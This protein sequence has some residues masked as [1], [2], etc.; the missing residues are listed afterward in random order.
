MGLLE[1]AK[2]IYLTFA[3]QGSTPATPDA[4]H[5]RLFFDDSGQPVVLDDAG[6]TTTFA[7]QQAIDNATSVVQ[8]VTA[9]TTSSTST[10]G[11]SWVDGLAA[12]ITP[13]F[14]DSLL[15]VTAHGQGTVSLVAGNRI[16]RECQFRLR[17]DTDGVNL[18]GAEEVDLGYRLTSGATTTDSARMRLT[19][20]LKG[21]YTVDSTAERT[22][23]AQLRSLHDGDVQVSLDGASSAAIM[24]IQEVR[25]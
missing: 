20:A 15:I 7:T 4:G 14:A 8:T 1:V 10:T 18:E 5:V 19:I 12:A 25:P 17:N 13:K 2:N 23:K 11:T 21:R 22:M 24:T 3:E 9:I 16:H 6:A